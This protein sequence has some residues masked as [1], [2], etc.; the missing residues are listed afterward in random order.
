MQNST[1]SPDT[2]K[3]PT[4]SCWRWL[5]RC[6]IGLVAVVTAVA[7]FYAEEDMRGKYDWSKY[8]QK[9]EARGVNLDWQKLVPPPVPDD[10]NFAMTPFLAPILDL[11]PRPFPS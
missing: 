10:Q 8:R 7:L 11:N 2:N 1:S 5:G 4:N 9:A 6:L 3:N